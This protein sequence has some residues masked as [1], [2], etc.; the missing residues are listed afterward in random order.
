MATQQR[1]EI[2]RD[3]NDFTNVSTREAL[4]EQCGEA[5]GED[6][7]AVNFVDDV[8]VGVEVG[9]DPD[10][11]D[12]TLD[13][14]V[15]GFEVGL[16]GFEVFAIEEELFVS[17]LGFTNGLEKVDDFLELRRKVFDG[18]KGIG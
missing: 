6:K 8:A 12:A 1:D 5:F 15:V 2:R 10:L 11:G 3:L 16:K 18:L 4:N 17:G 13:L 7:V 9:S 14:V